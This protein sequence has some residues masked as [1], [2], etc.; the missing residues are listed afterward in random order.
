[1]LVLAVAVVAAGVVVEVL[2]ASFYPLEKKPRPFAR[3]R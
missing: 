2:L 1:M 3:P